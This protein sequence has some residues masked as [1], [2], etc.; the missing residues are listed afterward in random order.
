MDL[1]GVVVVEGSQAG[2]G[3]P[4]SRRVA[5]FEDV[6]NRPVAHHV[7]DVLRAAGADQV[8]VVCSEDLAADARGCM[9]ACESEDSALQY[10]TQPGFVDVAAALRLAAPVVDGA[11]CIVHVASGLLGQPLTPFVDRLRSDAPDVVALVHQGA[12]P[13]E[14]LDAATL[15]RMHVAELDPRRAA[16]GTTGVWLFGPHALGC[17]DATSEQASRDV[18]LTGV[19]N[20]VSAAGG[21]FE[22]LAVDT[23]RRYAGNPVDLLELNRIALDNLQADLRRPSSNGNRIEGRVWIHEHASV[24]ASVIVGPTVIGPHA[25]IAEAY[26]GPY[27]SIG[28]GAHIEGAE[29]E[30]SIIGS[31]A[32]ILHV[33]GRIVA[34]VIG[35]D[36]RVFRD[37]SLPRAL[38]LRVGDGTE[39]ALC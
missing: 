32:S 29:I 12:S 8:V 34:S 27:T 11:P 1:R 39:V 14:H 6:A 4:C 30:R 25:R 36:A 13:H 26:I 10:L 22:V 24:H 28:A 3:S 37:F 7:V 38:R 15:E 17:L 35:R 31:G 23:W 18:D 33:G 19:A 16:F 5:A 9:S 21:E 2:D 20:R